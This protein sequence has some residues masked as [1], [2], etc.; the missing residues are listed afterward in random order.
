MKILFLNLTQGLVDRGLE[1]VVD[2]YALALSKNNQVTVVQAGPVKPEKTYQTIRS[3][4]LESA[5]Q[6]APYNIFEKLLFRLECDP[7]SVAALNFTKASLRS[8]KTVNPDIVIACNGAPQIKILKREMSSPKIVAFGQAG[9]GH[10]DLKTLLTKPDLFIALTDAQAI[11]CKKYARPSTKLVVIPNPV[12]I[13]KVSKKID[14][15]LPRPVVLTVG[16]L[17]HYKNITRIAKTLK[18]LPL[19]HI[20]IG[21]GEERSVLQDILSE[22]RYDFRWIKHVSPDEISAYYRYSDVFCFT[23]DPRE[24]FGNVYIEAMAAGLPIIA[25]DD[26]I[27]REIIGSLGYYVDHNDDQSIRSAVIKAAEAGRVDYSSQLSRYNIKVVS[28]LLERELY[29]LIK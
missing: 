5:P 13:S 27:R 22:R 19:T 26:P 17:S 9:M 24:A 12:D 2:L 7:A 11:W 14:L 15:K 16:A 20:I 1:R 29:D 10:H 28:K 18:S 23:P 21:D 25:T 8:I 3:L 6:A 4:K